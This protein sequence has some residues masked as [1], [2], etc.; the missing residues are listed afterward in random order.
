MHP[1]DADRMTSSVDHDQT[2][3]YTVCID[4]SVPVFRIFIV[5]CYLTHYC[6]IKDT[7]TEEEEKLTGLNQ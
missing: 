3:F 7:E 1:K 6:K 4:L 2:A 5:C